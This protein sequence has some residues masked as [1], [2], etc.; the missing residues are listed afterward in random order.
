MVIYLKNDSDMVISAIKSRWFELGFQFL[1]KM[2]LMVQP[3]LWKGLHPKQCVKRWWSF[4]LIFCGE[5]VKIM[6]KCSLYGDSSL[7]WPSHPPKNTNKNSFHR[8][9][10]IS[11]AG[12]MLWQSAPRLRFGQL[13]LFPC[14]FAH[15]HHVKCQRGGIQLCFNSFLSISSAGRMWANVIK[16]AFD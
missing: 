2:N 3:L 14:C 4:C 8:F 12:R 13:V 9:L 15:P 1:A 10:S 16:R 6:K 7:Y 11:S 5:M